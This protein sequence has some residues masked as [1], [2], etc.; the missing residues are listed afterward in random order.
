[1]NI[2]IFLKIEDREDGSSY[3]QGRLVFEYLNG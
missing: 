1:M 2:D 3:M